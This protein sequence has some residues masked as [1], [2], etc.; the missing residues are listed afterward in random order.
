MK[1]ANATETYGWFFI[2]EWLS[3]SNNTFEQVLW[4]QA[5]VFLK[6]KFSSIY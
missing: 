4:Y 3:N 6:N 5:T 1:K 2:Q